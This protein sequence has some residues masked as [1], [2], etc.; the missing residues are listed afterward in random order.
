LGRRPLAAVF[1]GGPAQSVTAS[2]KPS[3]AASP[4]VI[5]PVSWSTVSSPNPPGSTGAWLAGLSCVTADDCWAVG[6][7]GDVNYGGP[8]LVEQDTG[9]GWSIVPSPVPP[10]ST[11]S[12]LNAVSCASA[13]DCWAAGFSGDEPFNTS[14]L[15]EQDTGAG[16]T[17]VSDVAP[18]G[19]AGGEV[20]SGM[21]CMSTGHC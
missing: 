20:L 12:A 1:S 14:V 19:N 8:T 15:I 11:Q 9:S 18:T 5:G 16:W 7:W 17:I 6:G 10:G 4:T 13:A 3:V 21:T 2:A